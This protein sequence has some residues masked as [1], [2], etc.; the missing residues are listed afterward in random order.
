[1]GAAHSGK[2]YGISLDYRLEQA[3]FYKHQV[4]KLLGI[5]ENHPEESS[6]HRQDN[7]KLTSNR[8]PEPSISSNW[9]RI[10]Q[11][12]KQ[13]RSTKAMKTPTA[14]EVWRLAARSKLKMIL[15]GRSRRIRAQI[16]SP[17]PRVKV[18]ELWALRMLQKQAFLLSKM[19]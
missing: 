17:W 14:Q 11:R 13:D 12:N 19:P 6:R 5:L 9:G 18:V 16:L 4:L 3:T 1:M 8:L 2:N 15:P 7:N 10:R